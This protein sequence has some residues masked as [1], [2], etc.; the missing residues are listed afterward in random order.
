MSSLPSGSVLASVNWHG[1]PTVQDG[2]VN[3]AT[4]S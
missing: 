4:G 1:T 2:A 3:V